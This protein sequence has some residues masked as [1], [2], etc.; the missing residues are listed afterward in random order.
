MEIV[1]SFEHW[2]AEYV[3]KVLSPFIKEPSIPC[4]VKSFIL[5]LLFFFWCQS[6]NFLQMDLIYFLIS[7]FLYISDIC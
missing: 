1:P 7:L 5:L 4:L 6:S 3:F 2:L